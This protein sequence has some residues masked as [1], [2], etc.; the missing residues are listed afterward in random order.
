M[1]LERIAFFIRLC[2]YY[3]QPTRGNGYQIDTLGTVKIEKLKVPATPAE[4]FQY[5]NLLKPSPKKLKRALKD[6]WAFPAGKVAFFSFVIKG[7]PLPKG[8][9]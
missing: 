7:S 2:I 8:K 4:F 6:L 3:V 9:R 1:A 5:K